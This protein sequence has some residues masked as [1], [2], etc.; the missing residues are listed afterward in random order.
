MRPGSAVR[1]SAATAETSAPP[2]GIA[3]F[4]A[5]MV[6]IA[7]SGRVGVAVATGL[8]V[9]SRRLRIPFK[10]LGCCAGVVVHIAGLVKVP[11]GRFAGISG[12]GPARDLGWRPAA[13]V[14]SPRRSAARAYSAI[15]IAAVVERCASRVVHV[16]VV[17]YCSPAP[18]KSPTGPAPSITCVKSD[19]KS[20]PE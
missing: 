17:N 4:F 3:S 6:I 11:G 1:P 15:V 5:A 10:R 16:V 19:S 9:S 7:E 20:D 18:I 14:A 12:R 2:R 8:I 13:R